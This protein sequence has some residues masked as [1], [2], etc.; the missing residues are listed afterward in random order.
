M[1]SPPK[2]PQFFDLL[3][4]ADQE[5]YQKLRALVSSESCR[6][7]R[8]HRLDTFSEVLSSIRSF[9]EKGDADDGLRSLVCGVCHL[10]DSI[11]VN[12]RRL[13]LLVEKCK[14]SINGSF[15]RMGCLPFLG[16]TASLDILAERMPQIRGNHA[17]LREWSFRKIEVMTP[18]PYIHHCKPVPL[19]IPD[20]PAP[21]VLQY[22]ASTEQ[23][24]ED[25]PEEKDD[26]FCLRPS[27][28]GGFSW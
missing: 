22:G 3:S 10:S 24:S 21:Y 1:S 8:H 26:P 16:K 2:F 9:C 5:G 27:W 20:T 19:I 7:N 18:Q 11:A 23:R 15:Q 25:W 17:E 14:S 12:V 4:P 13:R 28:A 6:H